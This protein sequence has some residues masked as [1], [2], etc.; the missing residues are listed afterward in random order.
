[1]Q[2]RK[3]AKGLAGAGTDAAALADIL[4]EQTS[5]IPHGSATPVISF[6]SFGADGPYPRSR[7]RVWSLGISGL[8]GLTG[9]FS[10]VTVKQT[11]GRQ[12]GYLVRRA[13]EHQPLNVAETA[14]ADHGQIGL[15]ALRRVQNDLGGVA[16]FNASNDWAD[17]VFNP[18][19]S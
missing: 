6:C 12:M 13:A 2:L 3:L 16:D 1:V 15:L 5:A 17:V 18:A 4:S 8:N 14:A 10:Q 19:T 11:A 9:P 7:Q